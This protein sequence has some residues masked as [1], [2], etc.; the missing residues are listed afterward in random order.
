[1]DYL[2]NFVSC[3]KIGSGDITWHKMLHKVASKGKPVIIATGASSIQEVIEA[4]KILS[5]YDI[6][7]CLMQCNTNYTVS[8]ENFKYIIELIYKIFI[9]IVNIITRVIFYISRYSY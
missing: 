4:I 5:S 3:Y 8:P 7:I 9:Y 6:E 1:M 2:D